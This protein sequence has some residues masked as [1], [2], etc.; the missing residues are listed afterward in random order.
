MCN[1]QINSFFSRCAVML[2]MAAM[3]LPLHAS[4]PRSDY[5]SSQVAKVTAEDSSSLPVVEQH[6]S[7]ESS[8]LCA[9]APLRETITQSGN[10]ALRQFFYYYLTDHV[11]TVLRIV[12]EDGTVVNQYDYDAFGRV[13]WDSENTYENGVENRY[14]FQGREWD[15]NGG[16]YYFRNRIY[17]PERGEFASPDMNLGRG[18]LGEL[19]GMATLT[20]CGGDPVNMTDP[21][22]LAH[23]ESA[24]G[25]WDNSVDWGK[26]VADDWWELPLVGI[27]SVLDSSLYCYENLAA[28]PLM[29]GLGWVGEKDE[30]YG[31]TEQYMNLSASIPGFGRLSGGG[32]YA[33]QR[34]LSFAR[35][36][37]A[38]AKEAALLR[39]IASTANKTL[40]SSPKPVAPRIGTVVK[41]TSSSTGASGKA[42]ESAQPSLYYYGPKEY[43]ENKLS[44]GMFYGGPGAQGR[45]WATAD[46]GAGK[47]SLSTGGSVGKDMSARMIL[48]AEDAAKFRPAYGFEFSWDPLSWW[49]GA[50][51]QYYYRPV[52][53]GLDRVIELTGLGVKLTIVAT[54]GVYKAMKE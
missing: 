7:T 28:A 29:A 5:L 44:N 40:T 3:S 14:L 4:I 13:R 47:L 27:A 32:A 49:K 43:V 22:G 34:S 36:T 26:W 48:S 24:P 16:F 2:L 23:K 51:G 39:K 15:K 41:S 10:N 35:T 33:L 17:L 45:Y 8:L 21:T 9:S 42:A 11:G 53:T 46:A 25:L 18:I 30:E 50:S 54:P 6:A 37:V 20:F 1:V 12:K 38:S 52:T 19:D 31:V